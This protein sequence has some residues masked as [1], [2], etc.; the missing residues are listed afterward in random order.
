MREIAHAAG[1]GLGTVNFYFGTK[2]SLFKEI[3]E[4]VVRKVNAHRLELLK[5]DLK[6]RTELEHVLYAMI[7]PILSRALS[8]DPVER[9]VPRMI[10]SIHTGPPQVEQARRDE[11]DSISEQL[12]SALEK[13]CPGL[14]RQ[15]AIWCYSIVVAATYSWQVLEDRYAHLMGPGAKGLQLAEEHTERLIKFCAAGVAA[16]AKVDPLG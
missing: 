2:E 16:L 13:G 12:L 3:V 15:E 9:N 8:D 7:W 5:G 4:S 11:F 10:R 6:G 1:I 14:S